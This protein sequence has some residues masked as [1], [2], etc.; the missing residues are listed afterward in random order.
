MLLWLFHPPWWTW[1]VLVAA[2]AVAYVAAE[3]ALVV[4]DTR[5]GSLYTRWEDKMHLFCC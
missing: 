1:A 2:F 4:E 3:E 5:H